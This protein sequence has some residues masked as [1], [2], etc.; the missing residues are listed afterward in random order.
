MQVPKDVSPRMA[1]FRALQWF[2]DVCREKWI[3]VSMH[4]PENLAKEVIAAYNHEV[5]KYWIPQG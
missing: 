4:W 1:E 3:D 2:R 5:R